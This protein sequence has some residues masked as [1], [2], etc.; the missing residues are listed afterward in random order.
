MNLWWI[1]DEFLKYWGGGGWWKKI[2]IFRETILSHFI[3]CHFQHLNK[4]LWAEIL[5]LPLHFLINCSPKQ[6]W[7][8]LLNLLAGDLGRPSCLV[9]V[10]SSNIV[11]KITLFVEWNIVCRLPEVSDQ[12]MLWG[13]WWTDN[14]VWLTFEILAR[15][16]LLC[17]MHTELDYSVQFNGG[18]KNHP[19]SVAAPPHYLS[20][21]VLYEICIV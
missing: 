20:N 13:L 11:L 21:T 6:M 19:V 17:L 16:Y 18:W 1:F 9:N 10:V 3:L 2:F 8:L 4:M 15:F 7:C 12:S 5:N 14:F